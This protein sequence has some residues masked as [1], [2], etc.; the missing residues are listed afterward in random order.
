ML[1]KA[2]L[3]DDDIKIGGEV[4]PAKIIKILVSFLMKMD[5]TLV[6]MRKLVAGSLTAGLS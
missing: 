5:A 3:F 4:S 1:N 2:R 6:E